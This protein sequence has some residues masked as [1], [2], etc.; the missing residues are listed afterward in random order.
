MSSFTR[1]C[2]SAASSTPVGPPPT[3]AAHGGQR[4]ER[5]LVQCWQTGKLAAAHVPACVRQHMQGLQH[6]AAHR[7]SSHHYKAEV[8]AALL[9]REVRQPRML[10]HLAAQQTPPEQG[11]ASRLLACGADQS[12]TAAPS[13]TSCHH[14]AGPSYGPRRQRPAGPEPA[15][16]PE[17]LS[18]TKQPAQGLPGPPPPPD[19]GAQRVRIINPLQEEAAVVL[20]HALDAKRIVDGAHLRGSAGL[21]RAQQQ[22]GRSSDQSSQSHRGIGRPAG[23]RRPARGSCPSFLS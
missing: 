15:H 4:A 18:P 21:A 16:L 13:K 2:S 9:G 22:D 23:L 8:A 6:T 19:A 11:V 1:S 5:R 17:A 20:A 7:I 3:C 14:D 12:A 10:H